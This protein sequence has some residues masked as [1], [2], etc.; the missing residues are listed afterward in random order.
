MGRRN[1]RQRTVHAE[2]LRSNRVINFSTV[3]S[4]RRLKDGLFV[5]LS[6]DINRERR[7]NRPQPDKTLKSLL[8]NG[9]QTLE[10]P[11]KL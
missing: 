2:R 3:S 10:L 8:T 4:F 5:G 7:G 9:T 1:S 11:G 6:G